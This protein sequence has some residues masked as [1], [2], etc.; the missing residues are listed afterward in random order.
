MLNTN[1]R[2]TGLLLALGLL[3]ASCGSSKKAQCTTILNAI[4]D[5]RQQQQLGDLTRAAMM[6][7]A[8]VSDQLADQLNTLD[9]S[10]ENLQE[11]TQKLIQGHRDIASSTRAW[12]EMANEEGRISY[13]SGDTQTSQALDQVQSDQRKAHMKA[14]LGRDL[15]VSYCAI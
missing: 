5:S 15:I 6:Q 3:I 9:I 2:N 13:Q 7:N 1:L 8:D 4:E 10:N 12:A 11:H 14:Q